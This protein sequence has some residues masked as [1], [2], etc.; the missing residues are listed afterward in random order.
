MNG[1][2][3]LDEFEI[4]M[5]KFK[6]AKLHSGEEEQARR[7]LFNLINLFKLADTTPKLWFRSVLPFNPLLGARA[8]SLSWSSF[9]DCLNTICAENFV[10]QWSNRD[11]LTIQR[12]VDPMSEFDAN[13]LL[14]ESEFLG[15]LQ[16]LNMPPEMSE[17]MKEAGFM[18]DHIETYLNRHQ[19]R[20]RDVF[21]NM[22]RGRSVN[23]E[24]L[25]KGIE[26]IMEQLGLSQEEVDRD[27]SSHR[28]RH[29]R[30][31]GRL[32]KSSKSF[33][34]LERV[35]LAPMETPG[36]YKFDNTRSSGYGYGRI[37]KESDKKKEYASLLV[38]DLS[39]EWRNINGGKSSAYLLPQARSCQ[40]Q[41]GGRNLAKLIEKKSRRYA[42]N[43]A[44]IDSVVSN[45]VNRFVKDLS[46]RPKNGSCLV[47]GG[48]INLLR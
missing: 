18:L 33:S 27:L 38:E 11:L 26:S 48:Y 12:Y 7:L 46:V 40:F 34:Q 43:L 2:V 36:R 29:H 21:N 16:R 5:R 4:A 22:N 1:E 23:L 45:C 28:G 30:K 47:D 25:G 15:A 9:Q 32:E 8:E 20:V 41:D 13:N 10:E 39:R 44:G 42:M 31:P 6:H 37:V 19:I 3:S 14:T 24:Q 35:R 17:T